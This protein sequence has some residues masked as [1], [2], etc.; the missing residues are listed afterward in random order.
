MT[1]EE[2]KVALFDRL[3]NISRHRDAL[4]RLEET[5]AVQVDQLRAEGKEIEKRLK[6][7]AK[8][9]GTEEKPFRL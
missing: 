1:L 3:K 5:I 7:I 9:T 2:E 8:I 4:W 6:Q